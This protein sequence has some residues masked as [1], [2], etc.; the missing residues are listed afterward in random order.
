[1][2]Y[3]LLTLALIPYYCLS[4]NISYQQ[5]MLNCDKQMQEINKQVNN[6]YTTLYPYCLLGSRIPNFTAYT[7]DNRKIDSFYFLNKITIVNFWLTT[8]P[9]CIA[10]IPGLN[11]IHD[12]FKNKNVN[13]LAIGKNL[14]QDKITFL[15][16]HPWS[17]EQIKNGQ[18]VIDSAF[19][20]KW[21]YPTTL[22]IDEQMNI[23]NI[24]HGGFHDARAAIDIQ[25]KIIPVLED[26]LNK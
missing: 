22:I 3:I 12:K 11:I 26:K 17:F 23:I 7:T 1:M 8:C 9:P 16:L 18:E 15:T 20:I 14:E 19:K 2:K 6:N 13:F 21:G 5:A 24:F 25:N 10:E 4:Q